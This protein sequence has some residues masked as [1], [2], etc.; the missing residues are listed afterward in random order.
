MTE[1][2]AIV[3]TFRVAGA[4]PALPERT[5]SGRADGLWKTTCFELFLRAPGSEG[6]AELNFSPSTQ[7]A[8]YALASYREGMRDL[9]LEIDPVIEQIGPESGFPYGMQVEVDLSAVA[10]FTPLCANLTAVIEEADG[11]RSYWALAHPAGKPD[12]HD[13]ACFVL[14]LPAAKTP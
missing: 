10:G 1:R 6:Y 11:T 9:P 2:C 4:V 5:L 13:P 3:L 8:A 7:W 12:F 14:E